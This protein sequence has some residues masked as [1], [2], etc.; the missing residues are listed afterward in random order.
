MFK[1]F[2]SLQITSLFAAFPF[3]ISWLSSAT[4]PGHLAAMYISCVVYLIFFA[5]VAAAIFDSIKDW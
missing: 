3:F 1:A 2:N 5:M 4:F